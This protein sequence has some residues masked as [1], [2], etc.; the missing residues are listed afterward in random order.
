MALGALVAAAAH[1]V[2]AAEDDGVAQVAGH[3][4]RF[5]GQRELRDAA[6]QLVVVAAGGGVRIVMR[7]HFQAGGLRA[8]GEFAHGVG[9][10]VGRRHGLADARL[11]GVQIAF[12]AVGVLQQLAV[13]AQAARH[14]GQVVVQGQEAH[15]ALAD[16]FLAVSTP[17][18]WWVSKRRCTQCA[19][20]A[21]R[22]R[23]SE[24]NMRSA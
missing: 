16:P 17:P 15:A 18:T 1:D 7:G 8:G 9:H 13:V 19:P 2:G 24:S 22:M 11:E 6:A 4:S 14:A 3:A 21:S 23:S 5:T 20:S 10:G 12:G